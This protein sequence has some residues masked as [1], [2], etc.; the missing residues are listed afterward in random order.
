ME[1]NGLQSHNYCIAVVTLMHMATHLLDC[2]HNFHLSTCA[3]DIYAAVMCDCMS[4]T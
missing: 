3:H 1:N 2:Y 4:M